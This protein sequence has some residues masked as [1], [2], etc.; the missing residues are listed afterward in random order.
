[1]IADAAGVIEYVNPAFEA[2]TGYSAA[3]V[4]GK[5]PALLKSGKH[6]ARFYR[7]MWRTLRAGKA[8][9]G[10]FLNRRKS[11]ELFH[12]EE[13]IRPVRG[14]GARIAYF[15]SSG[16]DV[17]QQVRRVAKLERDATHDALTRLPNRVLFAD[18]L[19]HALRQA[20]RRKEGFVLAM[21]DLDGFREANN[22]FGHLAGD[23]VLR[24]VA[25][26]TARCIRKADTVARVGGDEFA[27]ILAG[28]AQR[29]AEVVLEKLRAAN[30]RPV[31]FEGHSIPLSVSIG[32]CFYPGDGRSEK[33]LRKGA[34]AA[35]YAA[36]RAGGNRLRFSQ[37]KV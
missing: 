1:M 21:F 9:R 5:T 23:A 28:A 2:L 12:E 30:A 18:R 19:A 15:V 25:K 10:I 22:R 16:R 3:E 34:D 7:R 32:A 35:M 8:F 33:A 24:A 14:P 26:R 31:R 4:V 36:K 20:A 6:D 29:G 11:G 17:T 27:L 37:G 13:I